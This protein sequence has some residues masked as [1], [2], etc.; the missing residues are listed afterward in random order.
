M[1]QEQTA[2]GLR[3]FKRVNSDH[4]HPDDLEIMFSDHRAAIDQPCAL[5][6]GLTN[7]VQ[8]YCRLA[9]MIMQMTQNVR[10]SQRVES[11]T[12]TT[13]LESVATAI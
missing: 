2:R 13:L 8:P 3:R 12:P 4:R 7:S 1:E 11:G 6:M 10:L 9:I 5:L